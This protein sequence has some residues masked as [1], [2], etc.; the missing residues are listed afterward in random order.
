MTKA[1]MKQGERP[2]H[3]GAHHDEHNDAGQP[4]HFH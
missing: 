3:P 4:M 1:G 2:S